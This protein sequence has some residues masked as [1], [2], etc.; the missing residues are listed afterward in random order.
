MPARRAHTPDN[1]AVI[2][3]KLNKLE[4]ANVEKVFSSAAA[5]CTT[6]SIRFHLPLK[7]LLILTEYFTNYY[8]VEHL[9]QLSPKVEIHLLTAEVPKDF[10]DV[11]RLVNKTTFT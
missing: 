10:M 8:K 9:R 11:S 4:F 3:N 1:A 6:P 5:T 7:V 2:P